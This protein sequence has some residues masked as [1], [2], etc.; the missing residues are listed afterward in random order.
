[1]SFPWLARSG[2]TAHV[3]RRLYLFWTE[4][5]RCLGRCQRDDRPQVRCPGGRTPRINST[6]PTSRSSASDRGPRRKASRSASSGGRG[7][8]GRR[9]RG[10]RAT[11]GRP[12]T[13][14]RRLSRWRGAL[15]RTL[16]A[17]SSFQTSVKPVC[18]PPEQRPSELA[19]GQPAGRADEVLVSS[20][21]GAAEELLPSRARSASGLNLASGCRPAYPTASDRS[22]WPGTR[23]CRRSRPNPSNRI[24]ERRQS[25]ATMSRSLGPGERVPRRDPRRESRVL[26]ASM[27]AWAEDGIDEPGQSS[28]CHGRPPLVRDRRRYSPSTVR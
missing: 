20:D 17:S 3:V 18:S 25:G 9:D 10:R 13:D 26:D 1:M 6:N 5:A 11:R 22:R 19:Q 28:A 7:V 27:P 12:Q 4:R 24:A 21:G 2:L 16:A 15:G 23:F 14:E 8:S